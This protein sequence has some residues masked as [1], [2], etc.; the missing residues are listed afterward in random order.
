MDN[1][2]TLAKIAVVTGGSRGIGRACSL[3]LARDG[4]DLA[5]AD[6][7]AQMDVAGETVKEIEALGRSVMPV[8]MDVSNEES[9]G[10]AFD[11]VAASMGTVT[12]LVNNAGV[13]RDGLIFKYPAD[14]FRLTID[15]NLVGAWLCSRAAVRG[16]L[17]ARWGRIVSIASAVALR[18]NPGQTAYTASK[19]G[20]VGITRSLAHE[21]GPRAVTVNAVCPGLVGTEMTSHLSDEQRQA[22]IGNTPLGRMATP[23]EVANVV[24][25]LMSD[26]AAFVTG[27]IVPVDGGLTA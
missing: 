11:E 18:G 17:R 20:I 26:E 15:I 10:R 25:F 6:L 16:M 9:V 24:R 23:E 4:W 14:V 3:A 13:G 2:E 21:V 27:A 22:M 8:E 12:G 19:S 7:P 5:I 1:T